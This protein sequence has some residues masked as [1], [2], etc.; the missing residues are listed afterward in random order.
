MINLSINEILSAARPVLPVITLDSSAAA[1]PLASALFRGGLRVIE[2]TLRTPAAFDAITRIRVEVPELIVGAGSVVAPGQLRAAQAAGAHF[3]V[4]P[5]LSST[6]VREAA[7]LGM[8][9]LP[10][11]MTPGEMMSALELGCATVKLFP[12]ALA[13][14]VALLKAVRGPIPG[15]QF[16]PTGG[17]DAKSCDDYL[18][19]DSVICVGGSWFLSHELLQEDWAGI[20]SAAQKLSIKRRS[21]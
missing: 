8:P 9:Y 12:A 5:G 1:G 4:S 6:L 2:V 14:G 20:Q 15:L 10:G 11:V 17:I 3:A 13:G 19:L 18:A 7:E 21:D 16:C